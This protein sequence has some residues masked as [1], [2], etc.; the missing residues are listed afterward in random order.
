MRV[1]IDHWGEAAARTH[2][3]AVKFWGG[4]GGYPGAALARDALDIIRGRC[5]QA[6][7][8]PFEL[9]APQSSSFRLDWRR[10]YIPID[11]GLSLN[12]HSGKI[13]TMGFPLVEIL[14]AVGLGNARPT[15]VRALEYRYAVIGIDSKIPRGDSHGSLF[16]RNLLC[17]ALG[18]ATLPFR[19]RIFQMRLG[20]PAKE[21][22]AR[23]ITTVTEVPDDNRTR[24]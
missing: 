23:A 6:G 8:A 15:R 22:Q 17:A 9:T 21:G 20:W 12:K 5:T 16:A 11:A 1:V 24:D 13:V 10:D 18:G 14:A 19:R 3:D 7:D 4:A 2:R